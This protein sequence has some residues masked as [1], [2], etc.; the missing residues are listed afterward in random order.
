[1]LVTWYRI[2]MSSKQTIC[3][4]ALQLLAQGCASDGLSREEGQSLCSEMLLF[5][6]IFA[7]PY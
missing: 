5:S 1:M 6:Q 7:H 4:P 2:V 3:P